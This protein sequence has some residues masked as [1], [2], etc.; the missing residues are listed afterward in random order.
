LRLGSGLPSLEPGQAIT[1]DY[2]AATFTGN[3]SQ[4]VALFYIP[5]ACARVLDK[6]LDPE[7]LMIPVL[8][9]QAA[10]VS[11]TDPIIPAG[12]GQAVRLDSHIFGPDMTATQRGWCYYFEKADLARQQGNW[13]QVAA[14]GDQAFGQNDYPNDPSERLVFIEGYAHAG[15][16]QRARQLSQESRQVT[17][18]M[19]PVL[20]RLWQRIAE[21]TPPGSDKEANL[22]AV[23][24]E[25]KCQ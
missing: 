14:L 4:M 2:L 19:Q 5:P 3:T 9:R 18:A 6:D 11:T 10:Q 12:P 16:W 25:L 1:Q 22:P 24:A 15:N 20:C 13:Q 17:S 23:R 21:S 8:M 7:N